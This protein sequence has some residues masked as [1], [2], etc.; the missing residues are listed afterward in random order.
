MQIEAIVVIGVVIAVI[1]VLAYRKR[2]AKGGSV[3][4]DGGGFTKQK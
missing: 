1:G 4:R 2:K 3:P